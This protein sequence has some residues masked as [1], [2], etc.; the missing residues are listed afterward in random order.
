MFDFLAQCKF[1]AS[2]SSKGIKSLRTFFLKRVFR[3]RR[4][5]DRDIGA[6]H[7]HIHRIRTNLSVNLVATREAN[8]DP[9][10]GLNIPFLVFCC[11]RKRSLSFKKTMFSNFTSFSNGGAIMASEHVIPTL[12]LDK[13][14]LDFV[15]PTSKLH[16]TFFL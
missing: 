6:G 7:S 16:N 2:P 15:S 8:Y 9:G 10:G 11:A 13:S 3:L 4:L 1:Y 14:L 5:E 12:V